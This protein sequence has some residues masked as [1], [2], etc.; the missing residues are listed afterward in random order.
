MD[1]DAHAIPHFARVLPRKDDR[2]MKDDVRN[3][4]R[5]AASILRSE[6]IFAMRAHRP[7]CFDFCFEFCFDFCFVLAQRQ[8][9]Q[10]HARGHADLPPPCPRPLPLRQGPY[11][12]LTDTR[13]VIRP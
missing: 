3:Q 6:P 5:E 1:G 10:R 8:P 7:S 13:T 2:T 9:L 12:R 11:R 4:S